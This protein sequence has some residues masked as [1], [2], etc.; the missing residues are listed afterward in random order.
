LHVVAKTGAP[1]S[2]PSSAAPILPFLGYW[3]VV[4]LWMLVISL[5][6]GEPFSARNTH[7]YIDPV[8]RFFFPDLTKAG[9]TLAHSII[10]KAAH[11][12]EFFV[13]GCLTYWACRRGR[14]PLWKRGWAWQTFALCMLYALVDE[15]HQSFVPNRTP[16]PADSAVDTAGAAVALVAIY[17]RSRRGSTSAH[18]TRSG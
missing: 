10:R 15:M 3:S 6:S 9:F 11:F 8:L 13:L 14:G 7:Q 5:L 4:A 18:S 1:S 16:S 17:L 12:G 2:A